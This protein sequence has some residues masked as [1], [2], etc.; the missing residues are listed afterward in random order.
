MTD[1]E[2]KDVYTLPS[3]A[4]D[5][6]SRQLPKMYGTFRTRAVSFPNTSRRLAL[7]MRHLFQIKVANSNKWLNFPSPPP[8]T[9]SSH[10]WCFPDCPDQR[11]ETLWHDFPGTVSIDYGVPSNRRLV[12]RLSFFLSFFF[13]VLVFFLVAFLCYF[14]SSSSSSSSSLSLI[15]I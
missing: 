5:R 3:P 4:N 6:P 10:R 8:P 1:H 13:L 12:R 7:I 14:S 11:F 15:H 9:P 2:V